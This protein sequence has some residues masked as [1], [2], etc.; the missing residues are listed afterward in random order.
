LRFKRKSNK[1]Y[2]KRYH[3]SQ[4][5]ATSENQSLKEQLALGKVKRYG[6]SSERLDKQIEELERKIV[7]VC[8]CCLGV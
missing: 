7:S 8:V 1:L 4:G 2:R 6:K 3:N 5:S